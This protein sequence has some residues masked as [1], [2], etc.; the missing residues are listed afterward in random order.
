VNGSFWDCAPEASYVWEG[1][2]MSGSARRR[3]PTPTKWRSRPPSRPSPAHRMEHRTQELPP[4]MHAERS[5]ESTVQLV[6][7]A[8]NLMGETFL[9]HTCQTSEAPFLQEEVPLPSSA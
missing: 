3:P 2:M 9:E 5:P 6:Q 4:T 1:P 7:L 8:S